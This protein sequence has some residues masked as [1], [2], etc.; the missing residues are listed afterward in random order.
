MEKIKIAENVI[1]EAEIKKDEA[2]TD[3]DERLEKRLG[4]SA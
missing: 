4:A 1:D 3:A 2:K